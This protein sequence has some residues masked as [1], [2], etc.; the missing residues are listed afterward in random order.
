MGEE[1]NPALTPWRRLAFVARRVTEKSIRLLN[2]RT[3]NAP[4]EYLVPDVRDF[5]EEFEIYMRKELLEAELA[6]IQR[7]GTFARALEIG[8]QLNEINFKIAE[9]EN[10]HAR[11]P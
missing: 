5:E 7:H 4:A 8:A 6:V 2:E 3:A 1:T 10:Q 11:Q 9:R